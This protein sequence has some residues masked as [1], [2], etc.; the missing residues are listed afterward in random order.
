MKKLIITLV[1]LFSFAVSVDA[2][3]TNDPIWYVVFDDSLSSNQWDVFNIKYMRKT[4][5][6]SSFV[7]TNLVALHYVPL[8]RPARF[9]TFYNAYYCFDFD[10]ATNWF[11]SQFGQK[12]KIYP[13]RNMNALY[14]EGFITT[15]RVLSDFGD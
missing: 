11:Q 8:D 10:S 6:G 5:S 12:G 4:D 7:W 14:S 2:S 13:G 15:N 9:L 3:E 1:V